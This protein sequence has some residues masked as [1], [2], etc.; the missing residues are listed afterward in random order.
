M[1]IAINTLME[2]KDKILSECSAA[3]ENKIEFLKRSIHELTLDSQNEAKSSAGDKHETTK[4]QIQLEQEKLSSQLIQLE[5][6]QK[7]FERVKNSSAAGKI[8]AGSIIKT[9]KG[10]FILGLSIGEITTK[11]G[12]KVL[13]V[14]TTSPIGKEMMGRSKGESFSIN[15]NTFT[16]EDIL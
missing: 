6:Q 5:Q 7:T 13:P 3:L 14:S 1:D 12:F 4:S 8:S 10:W 11:A 9:N 2:L 16:I 15:N